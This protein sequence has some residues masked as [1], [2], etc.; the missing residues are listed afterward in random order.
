MARRGRIFFDKASLDF[1]KTSGDTRGF[2][3]EAASA[4]RV[5]EKG[6]E[7]PPMRWGKSVKHGEK[8][9]P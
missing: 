4:R 5:D 8:I 3:T 9:D 6:G 7:N 2:S 1:V